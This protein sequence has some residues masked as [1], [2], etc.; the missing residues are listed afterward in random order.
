M[1]VTVADIDQAFEAYQGIQLIPS[2]LLFAHRFEQ[3]GYKAGEDV[4]LALDC[5]A[6]EFYH[7]AEDVY[8]LDGEGL[9]LSSTQFADYL[10]NL[11]DKFPI[12]SIEDGMAEGDREGLCAALEA[13]RE[14]CLYLSIH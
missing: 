2:W 9:K 4:L 14:V 1:A 8:Q 3:A 5:A 13:E 6:S 12:V 11:C 7:E 10:A